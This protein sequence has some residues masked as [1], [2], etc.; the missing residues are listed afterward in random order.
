[1]RPSLP[2]SAPSSSV[3]RMNYAYVDVP[4]SPYKTTR[5]SLGDASLSSSKENTPLR[6][7]R[8]SDAISTESEQVSTTAQGNGSYPTRLGRFQNIRRVLS[9]TLRS[10]GCRDLLL[11]ELMKGTKS[12]AVSRHLQL[13]MNLSSTVISATRNVSCQTAFNVQKVF[14]LP[15]NEDMDEIKARGVPTLSKKDREKH[16]LKDGY[17]YED[18]CN[19]RMCRK[20]KGLE[21][22]GKFFPDQAVQ[23]KRPAP[24]KAD[25]ATTVPAKA[26][27]KGS[28]GTSASRPKAKDMKKSVASS[29]PAESKKKATKTTQ[30]AQ[31]DGVPARK[32]QTALDLP[33]AEARIYIREFVQRFSPVLNIAKT[34]LDELEEVTGTTGEHG[35]RVGD[36]E[37]EVEGWRRQRRDRRVVKGPIGDVR[38]S[39]ANLNKIWLALAALRDGLRKVPSSPFQYPDPSLHPL[40]SSIVPRAARTKRTTTSTSATLPSSSLSS[41][42]SSR[43]DPQQDVREEINR[44]KALYDELKAKSKEKGPTKAEREE[45]KQALQ[46]IE[47]A[48]RL[49]SSSHILRY[50]SLGQDHEGRVYYL[51]TPS[52]AEREAALHL[53]AGKNAK[54]K[55]NRRRGG[56]TE[57]DRQ[58]MRRWSWIVAVWGRLPEG[59]AKNETEDS[60]DEDD[61]SEERWWGFYDPQE[62]QKMAEWIAMKCELGDVKPKRRGQSGEASKA[63]ADGDMLERTA[64]GSSPATS[65]A[66]SPMSDLSSDEDEG[67][68][69]DEDD[70]SAYMRVDSQGRPVPTRKQLRE[71]VN[72]LREYADLLQWRIRRI[73]G[74]PAGTAGEKAVAVNGSIPAKKFYQ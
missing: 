18:I 39:G 35:A 63:D 60:E 38:A 32:P 2:K 19:C 64:F 70:L 9:T 72:G 71:L 8:R 13:W 55:I 10:R 12:R 48:H 27:A 56:L 51:L 22:T 28:T 40:T 49:A 20:A 53:V 44:Q 17:Y 36:T 23:P 46:N 26:T 67:D 16:I 33:A 3:S 59:A 24:T 29:V 42:R 58:A 62:I 52:E 5:Q 34:H 1:M 45:H 7:S 21:P 31:K 66:P 41:R 6:P 47:H 14:I 54:V 43:E 74:E 69:D 73:S 37:D 30:V 25:G 15:Y 65:R 57:E 4:P 68:G 61:G 11:P 50:A